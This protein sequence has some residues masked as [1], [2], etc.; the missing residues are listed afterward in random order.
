MEIQN[1]NEVDK[2]LVGIAKEFI[3]LKLN[4]CLDDEKEKKFLEDNYEKM[5]EHYANEADFVRELNE[6]INVMLF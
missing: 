4:D 5:K 6:T 3:M 1:Q 2:K